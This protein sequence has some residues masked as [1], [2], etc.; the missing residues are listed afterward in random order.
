M[1][2]LSEEFRQR[3]K[4]QSNSGPGG[5]ATASNPISVPSRRHHPN[6]PPSQVG[7]T[8]RPRTEPPVGANGTGGGGNSANASPTPRHSFPR[9]HSTSDSKGDEGPGRGTA[10]RKINC[11]IRMLFSPK[12]DR[13]STR[14]NSSH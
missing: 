3:S 8:R 4:S 5:G 10:A 2:A 6:P 9:S 13:K 14:L 11:C 12:L 1:K 7:F